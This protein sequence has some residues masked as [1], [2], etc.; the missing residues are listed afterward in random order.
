MT[1]LLARL[2]RALSSSRLLLLLVGAWLFYYVSFAVWSS[3][4]FA[5]FL[6][7][8]GINHI[9]QAV[10]LLFLVTLAL[11]IVRAGAARLKRSRAMFALWAVLP[12]GLFLFIT[13]FFMSVVFRESGWNVVAAGQPVKPPWQQETYILRSIEPGLKDRVLDID[14]DP[15]IFSYEPRAVMD[16]PQGRVEVGVFPP[17]RI[18]RTYYH[19]LDFGL[20]PGISLFQEG[21]VVDRAYVVLRILPPGAMDYF[22]LP[23]LP[24]RFS[25]KLAPEEVIEKGGSRARVFNIREPSYVLT[26]EKG[27]E[28][29]YEGPVQGRVVLEDYAIEVSSPEYWVRL[30]AAVN[31]GMKVFIAG[32][33]LTALG[34][35]LY[36]PLL[37]AGFMGR[38]S[39]D[40]WL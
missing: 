27:E 10:F 28:V 19:I 16:T 37:V 15:G 34:L 38:R 22:T 24:H 2:Y 8:L 13:G 11:N 31:P 20:A 7:L 21:R 35:V 39:R 4:A 26:A 30:E 17:A 6:A 14:Q 18:G 1:R 29:V 25:L 32:I 3:E 12:L 9:Y 33:A 40:S 36:V 5:R 23:P